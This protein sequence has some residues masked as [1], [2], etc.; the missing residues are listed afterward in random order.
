MSEETEWSLGEKYFDKI[1]ARL[2]PFEID[3]FVTSINNKCRNFVFWHLDPLAQAVDAFS[4]NWS[5][6]Y[7]FLRIPSFY[8]YF[9]K[10]T[11]NYYGQGGEHCCPLVAS[12]TMVT[13]IQSLVVSQSIKF[14]P[15][16]DQ[17]LSF[18]FR[19]IHSAWSK[20]SLVAA[21][22]SSRLFCSKEHRLQH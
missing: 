2:G 12:P 22:L 6:Y 8:F 19:E 18:P 5:K 20:I 16:I 9:K 17:M 3:L 15:N 21:K 4:L 10:H 1:D 11:K 14:L 13:P 7:L